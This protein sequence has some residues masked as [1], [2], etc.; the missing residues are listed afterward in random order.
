[1]FG[2]LDLSFSNKIYKK[3]K[4]NNITLDIINLILLLG[5]INLN[6]SNGLAIN[7]GRLALSQ[8]FSIKISLQLR[9]NRRD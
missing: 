9:E 8:H 5:V 7:K 2:H 1:M 3:S 4:F 6:Y